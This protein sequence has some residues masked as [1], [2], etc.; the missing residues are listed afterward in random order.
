MTGLCIVPDCTQ[1]GGYRK[2]KYCRQHDEARR[3]EKYG[4]CPC[5]R[6]PVWSNGVCHM[7]QKQRWR[8]QERS[9][10]LATTFQGVDNNRDDFVRLV[11]GIIAIL[12]RTRAAYARFLLTG[13][14]ALHP[15]VVAADT[16][17]SLIIDTLYP[18]QVKFIV[19][20]VNDDAP[21]IRERIP[22][23]TLRGDTNAQSN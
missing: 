9:S 7:C 13:K 21:T 10:W 2:S 3:L 16:L 11:M 19:C 15:D 23:L 22:L 1:Q 6:A 14:N 12:R 4:M 8:E 18:R 5:G 17:L 20:R